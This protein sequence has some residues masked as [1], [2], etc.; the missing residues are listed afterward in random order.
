MRG[1]RFINYLEEKHKELLETPIQQ[2][3]KIIH[4]P[5]ELTANSGVRVIGSRKQLEACGA[6]L[7]TIITLRNH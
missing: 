3:P 2:L 6:E 4:S 1:L 5:R 7:D